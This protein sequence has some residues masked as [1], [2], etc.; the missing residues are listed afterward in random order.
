LEAAVTNT[1]ESSQAVAVDP[2][3]PPQ[4]LIF[5]SHDSRDAEMAEAFS[6]LLASISA[7][8]L[9]SFRSSDNKGAQGLEYGSDWY[10][11]IVKKVA[12]AS[13]VVCLL[14]DRSINRPWILYE[15][16]LAKGKLNAPVHGLALGIPLNKAS[17]GPFA[18]FQN[19]GDDVESLTKLAIQLVKRL[20]SAA[21]E[22]DMVKAQVEVFKRRV[23]S[24]MSSIREGA[25][26]EEGDSQD[27]P[28][29]ARL[30]E[31][32]KLMFQELPGRI[33][34]IASRAGGKH[35]SV[36]PYDVYI[37]NEI[38]EMSPRF[39]RSRG[40][41]SLMLAA[42]FR[43]V[44]PWLYEF[45]CEMYRAEARHDPEGAK[46]AWNDFTKGLEFAAHIPI[47][48]IAEVGRNIMVLLQRYDRDSRVKD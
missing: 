22:R 43:N 42:P 15:A 23:E 26:G 12:D 4:P 33:D 21:P 25:G 28:A 41:M 6:K 1:A 44:L 40:A 18:Q 34:E 20:P 39:G 5:I 48:N 37:A 13:D 10:P 46:Q 31:E 36:D 2:M 7:G 17:T 9:K 30:F 14:T 27:A 8:M 45:S 24:L 32:I 19:C 11:E 35:P 47:E 29:S 16:G 38:A 3:A